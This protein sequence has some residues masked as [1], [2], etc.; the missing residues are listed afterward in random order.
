M[1]TRDYA[2][3]RGP[4][5]ACLGVARSDSRSGALGRGRSGRCDV[6]GVSQE[7]RRPHR[8]RPRAQ[9]SPSMNA[10][11][12]IAGGG[13]GDGGG[14]AGAGRGTGGGCD[15][16]TGGGVTTAGGGGETARAR[17]AGAGRGRGAVAG[18]ARR[19]ACAVLP[20]AGGAGIVESTP[21]STLRCDVTKLVASPERSWPSLVATP[22]LQPA[23]AT[24]IAS[25]R[26][27]IR[28]RPVSAMTFSR[29]AAP[30]LSRSG[31]G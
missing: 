14:G 21:I 6:L 16:T 2:G 19:R 8:G 4:D 3:C 20:S 11:P 12:G 9:V 10:P 27:P 23:A 28:L 7:R 5:Q 29:R 31:S 1:C 17:R 26:T 15:R 18:A 30:C 13:G 22:R 25:A 24:A